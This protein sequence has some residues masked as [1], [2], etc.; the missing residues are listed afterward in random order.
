MYQKLVAEIQLASPGSPGVDEVQTD[1]TSAAEAG[2]VGKLW[3]WCS[4]LSAHATA[5]FILTG[6]A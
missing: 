2:E 3:L 4:M 1:P 5:L 6:C